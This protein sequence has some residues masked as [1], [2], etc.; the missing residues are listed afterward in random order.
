MRDEERPP[1]S[2]SIIRDAENAHEPNP[3]GQGT[4]SNDFQLLLA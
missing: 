2:R 1:F 3:K 4:P